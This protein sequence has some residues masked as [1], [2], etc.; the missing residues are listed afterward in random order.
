MNVTTV[1]TRN[2]TQLNIFSQIPVRKT[3]S[4]VLGHIS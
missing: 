2:E 1:E 3:S 4:K